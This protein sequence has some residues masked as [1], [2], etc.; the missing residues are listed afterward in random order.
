MKRS[1]QIPCNTSH[2]KDARNFLNKVLKNTGLNE[3]DQNAIVLAVDEV[4]A[5]III[6]SECDNK[7]IIELNVERKGKKLIF[8]II[9]QGISTFD[10][11][12]YSGPELDEIIQSKRK[13]GVGILLVKKI[14]DK[15]EI[16]TSNGTNICRL[17]KTI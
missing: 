7:Q 16:F 8:E 14:M 13:G 3:T 10:I 5:N 9:D 4:C 6:H 11:N 15:I 1:F 2:L 12:A 17:Y